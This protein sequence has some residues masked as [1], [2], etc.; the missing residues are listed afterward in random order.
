[1]KKILC[2]LMVAIL[3]ISALAFAEPATAPQLTILEPMTTEDKLYEMIPVLDSLARNMGIEGEVVY[4]AGNPEF[5]WTQIALICQNWSAMN[6]LVTGEGD[7]LTIPAELVQEYAWASFGG[8]QQLP[9]IP[10]TETSIAYDAAASSYRVLLDEAP[11]TYIMIERYAFD[12]AGTLYVGVGLYNAEEDDLRLGGLLVTLAEPD[13]LNSAYSADFPYIVVNAAVEH[14][15]DFANLSPVEAGIRYI[16]LEGETAETI[17]QTTVSGYAALSSGDRG[18][19][20]RALQTR[21]NEL[22]YSCGSV[23]GIFG[24][25]TRRAVRYFQ[26]AIGSTQNGVASAAVQERLFAANAPEY[27][28][29]VT[30]SKGSSGIRVEKLQSRLRELG[31]LAEP[32]DGD[33]GSRTKEAVKLF[34]KAVG[35]KQDGV[36]GVKTLKA[37]D[38]SSAPE[39]EE[40][41]TLK[42]GDTGVRVKEL[43]K[44]LVELGFMTGKISGTFDSATSR[45]LEAYMEAAGVEGS[46]R[47]VD[48]EFLKALFAYEPTVEPTVEPTL[49][50]TVEPTEEPTVEPTLEPTVEPT[51]E[52]TVEPTETPTEEPTV[53]PTETPTEAPVEPVSAIT[54]E[55]LTAI[56]TAVNTQLETAKTAT[57]AVVW[58][59]HQLKLVETGVYDSITL[60]AVRAFQAKLGVELPTGLVDAAT[61][62]ALAALKV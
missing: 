37:L 9:E 23:D 22:G 13:P 32:M 46:S 1:M 17:P 26:D 24:S 29:Y 57:E 51:E 61:V 36:A 6:A 34:Q 53:E 20:V 2:I 5:V 25:R 11:V 14:E 56:V 45:A 44:K 40:F 3:A 35:L 15:G 39:C 43:Q 55:Q 48:A 54:A 60:E 7:A 59:Q 58:I 21:L 18:D 28:T 19:A 4:D 38:K 50:P 30:L 8:M 52:P 16:A 10:L 42:R 31:Y 33:F 62:D 49:E 41:I 27:V 47:S 12:A